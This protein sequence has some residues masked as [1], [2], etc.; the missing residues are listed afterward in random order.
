MV[1]STSNSVKVPTTTTPLTAIQGDELT[2]HVNPLQYTIDYTV[3]LFQQVN[4][5]VTLHVP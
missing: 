3:G 2:C 4:V 5:Y 1:D